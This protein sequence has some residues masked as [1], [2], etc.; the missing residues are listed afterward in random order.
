MSYAQY[1]R[2]IGRGAEGARNLSADDARQ[3]YG[4]MLDGGVPDLEMGAIILGLRVKG[5]SLAEMLGFLVATE[6][7]THRHAPAAWSAAADGH[8]HL[9]RRA[10]GSQPDAALLAMMLQHF[11][12]P[13]LVHGLMEGYGRVT[14]GHVFRELGIMP[15]SSVPAAQDLLE[16]SGL[17]FMPL[18]A[19]S[20]GA[21]NLLVLRSRLGVRNSA[22]S[23]VKLL[24]P[25]RGDS[26]APG[27]GNASG[28]HR[29][30]ASGSEHTGSPG[31]SAARYRRGTV[32]QP[33]A[34][35]ASRISSTTTQTISCSMPST[36]AF[37]PCPTCRRRSM[38]LATAGLDPSR[39]RS[40]VAPAQVDRQPA[41]LLSRRLR[42]CRRFLPGQGHRGGQGWRPDVG[43]G[44]ARR[45]AGKSPECCTATACDALPWC[46][47]VAVNSNEI[48]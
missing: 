14:T 2:E 7:R 29:T 38:R 26:V 33:Q 15:T 27:C 9:Q 42:L 35:A 44:I 45:S 22:H 39:A 20:P 23:L 5:E 31:D 3:L 37:V 17:V 41:G 28:L 34:A 43:S 18:S 16:E 10:Q 47:P 21:H 6:E 48:T 13:V 1:I 40:P 4:A 12:V 8:S 46:I 25:F 11:G 32:C 19:L 24:D 30:D 36:T